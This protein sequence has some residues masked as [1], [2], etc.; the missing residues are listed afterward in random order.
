MARHGDYL[1]RRGG[2]FYA[3]VRVPEP[4]RGMYAQSDLRKSLN[5][6]N[7]SEARL[8]VLEAVLHWKRDF[9]RAQT[10]LDA[11]QVVIGSPLLLGEGLI[12]LGSAARP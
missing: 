9:L 2:I 1:Y 11:R 10:M 12:S 3:R 5:T 4:L 8:R 7:Y 6:A